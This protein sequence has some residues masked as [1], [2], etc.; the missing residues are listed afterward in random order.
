MTIGGPLQVP[1]HQRTGVLAES[2][3]SS[4]TMPVQGDPDVEVQVIADPV[5]PLVLPP[6]AV[7]NAMVVPPVV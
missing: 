7:A 2:Q 3:I 5:G 1:N 6:D 4:P